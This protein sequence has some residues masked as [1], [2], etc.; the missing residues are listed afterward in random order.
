VKH[1]DLPR[2]ALDKRAQQIKLNGGCTCRT[3][4]RRICDERRLPQSARAYERNAIAYV[5]IRAAGVRAEASVRPHSKVRKTTDAGA[6]RHFTCMQY[7]MSTDRLPRQARDISRARDISHRTVCVGWLFGRHSEPGGIFD[8]R[9]TI[10]SLVPT[11]LHSCLIGF[12]N[13]LYQAVSAWLTNRE[14]AETF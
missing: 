7:Y 14:G 5:G 2:Q 11:L 12:L 1:D 10:R 6:V 3:V 8:S 4:V 13:K 9:F